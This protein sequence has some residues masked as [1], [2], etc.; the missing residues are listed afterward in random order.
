MG[1]G[2]EKF[3]AFGI[4]KRRFALFVCAFTMGC[5]MLKSQNIKNGKCSQT[6]EVSG[7][8]LILSS[9]SNFLFE[10][11]LHNDSIIT[12]KR[13]MVLTDSS[14]TLIV[15]LDEDDKYGIEDLPSIL[16]I[17]NPFENKVF[18]KVKT[19]SKKSENKFQ[20]EAVLPLASRQFSSMVWPYNV[21]AIM[22]YDFRLKK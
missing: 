16:K 12:F 10:A 19:K 9:P 4:Q 3:N 18:Y 21:D 11:V 1:Q 20:R 6:I 8:T 2:I 13:I 22:L 5:L 7:D 17:Y 14:K 15:K